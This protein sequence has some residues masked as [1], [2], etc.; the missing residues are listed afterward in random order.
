MVSGDHPEKDN[1][2]TL[3]DKNHEKIDSR[4]PV[5][6]NNGEEENFFIDLSTKLKDQY[7]EAK[8]VVDKKV[9]KDLLSELSIM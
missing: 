6:V 4:D 1:S 8:E 7:P 9:P 3:K 2:T 5:I